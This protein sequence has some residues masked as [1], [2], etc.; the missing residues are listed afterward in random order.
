MLLESDFSSEL[1]NITT[2]KLII[3]GGEPQNFQE[4]QKSRIN[5]F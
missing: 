3:L 5:Q 1:A 4:L 2:L